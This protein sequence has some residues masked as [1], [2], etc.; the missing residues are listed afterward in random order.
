MV[1]VGGA[2]EDQRQIVT[3]E[4]GNSVT[5]LVINTL[6]SQDGLMILGGVGGD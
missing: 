3:V 5:T 2:S 6:T 4:A 1:V